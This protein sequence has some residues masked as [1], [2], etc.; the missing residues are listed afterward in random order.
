VLKFGVE[1]EMNANSQELPQTSLRLWVATFV[2]MVLSICWI[3]IYPDYPLWLA[4]VLI[5]MMVAQAVFFSFDWEIVRHILRLVAA[6]TILAGASWV[7]HCGLIAICRYRRS[8][9]KQA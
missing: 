8:R 1:E 6:F 4:F 2:G 3:E 5:P 7:V 9:S